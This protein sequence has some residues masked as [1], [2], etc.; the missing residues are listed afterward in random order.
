MKDNFGDKIEVTSDMGETVV[1][2]T[3]DGKT[4]GMYLSP[5]KARKLIR[6]LQRATSALEIAALGRVA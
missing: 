1:R 2:F 3:I 4:T 5:K 6:K